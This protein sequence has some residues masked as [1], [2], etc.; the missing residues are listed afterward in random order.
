M[1]YYDQ[2]N[3]CGGRMYSTS[4]EIIDRVEMIL[5]MSIYF[6]LA[7]LLFIFFL[8]ITLPV[9]IYVFIRKRIEEVK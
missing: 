9:T 3:G 6:I 7:S 1:N 8:S 4:E 2:K 5:V